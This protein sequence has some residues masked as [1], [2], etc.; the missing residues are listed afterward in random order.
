[1][2]DDDPLGEDETAVARAL[3]PDEAYLFELVRKLPE[4]SLARANEA[5]ARVLTLCTALAGGSVVLLK[6]DVCYGWW[7][8]AAAAGFFAA[9][10]TAIRGTIPVTGT[11]GRTPEAIKAAYLD[12]AKTKW[13]H[14]RAAAGLLLA[15]LFC[16]VAGV[17]ARQLYG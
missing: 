3:T 9:L 2:T 12:S 11:M 6:E 14:I 1:M 13:R 8:V 5:L 10:M 15:G 7:K 16:A 17:F 4:T